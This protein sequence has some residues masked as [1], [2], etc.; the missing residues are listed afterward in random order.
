MFL[1][2]KAGREPLLNRI[3]ELEK[4]TEGYRYRGVEERL[5]R[6]LQ[7]EREKVAVLI[8]AMKKYAYTEN[9]EVNTRPARQA[10]AKVKEME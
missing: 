7:A 2:W 1:A 5:R 4:A 3:D 10:L 8:E 6:Q 9:R